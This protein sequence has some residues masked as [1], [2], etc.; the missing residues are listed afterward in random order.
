MNLL[1]RLVG[2]V[3]F[4]RKRNFADL[5]SWLLS[6]LGA[7]A[8]LVASYLALMMANIMPNFV[9]SVNKD[10]MRSAYLVLSLWL[11]FYAVAGWFCGCVAARCH[12]LLF[13]RRFK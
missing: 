11:G 9:Q 8:F 4:G 5:P 7:A 1:S 10:G 2:Y 13:S 3:S 6:I 12:E